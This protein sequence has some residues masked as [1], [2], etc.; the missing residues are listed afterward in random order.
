MKTIIKGKRT[1]VNYELGYK[2]NGEPVINS[3]EESL[4]DVEVQVLENDISFN[5][6]E[7]I[8]FDENTSAKVL[9]VKKTLDGITYVYTNY[10]VKE[11]D[12]EE[13]EFIQK[14]YD[15]AFEKYSKELLKKYPNV[16]NV[17][18]LMGKDNLSSKEIVEAVKSFNGLQNDFFTK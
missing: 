11:E 3:N 18:K 16:S 2:S 15:K 7:E 8:Y 9:N 14:L 4:E 10:K 5:K 17:L 6:G 1:K 12:K 13:K